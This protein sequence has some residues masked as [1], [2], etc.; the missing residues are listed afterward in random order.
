MTAQG[1]FRWGRHRLGHR[2][3][4]RHGGVVRSF[5]VIVPVGVDSHV[6]AHGAGRVWPQMNGMNTDSLPTTKGR[7]AGRRQQ[8][9]I[10]VYLCPSVAKNRTVVS[11]FTNHCASR[12]FRTPVIRRKGAGAGFFSWLGSSWP[13]A[14]SRPTFRGRILTAAFTAWSCGDREGQAV[15]KHSGMNEMGDGTDFIRVGPPPCHRNARL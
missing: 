4:L 13:S 7:N 10:C 15:N 11:S 14:A 6:L 8:A 12:Q 9:C 1:S 5:Q 3:R 2:L